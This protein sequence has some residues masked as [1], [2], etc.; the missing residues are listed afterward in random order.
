MRL[1]AVLAILLSLTVTAHAQGGRQFGVWT[2]ACDPSGYCSATAIDLDYIFSIGRHAEQSY[3]ELRYQATGDAVPDPAQGLGTRVDGEAFIFAPDTVGA[4]GDD[5][6]FYL[7][8]DTAQALMDR[9]MPGA[10]L[11]VSFFEADGR[12]T[13]TTFSLSGLTAALLWIDEQQGR[14]GSERV[15]SAPP[16]GLVPVY[17]GT[18]VAPDLPLALLDRHR[19]DPDCPPFEELANGRDF[20]VGELGDGQMVYLIPCVAAAYNYAHK[21]YVGS[22]D[23][24]YFDPQYFADF[25]SEIGWMGTPYIWNGGYDAATRTLT[26]F[27]KARGP[28]DCGSQGI[29]QWNGYAF[30]LTEMRSRD[31]DAELDPNGE[32]PEFPVIYESE[33]QTVE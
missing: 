6:S 27:M 24:P 18:A 11:E 12:P 15:A 7:L 1:L 21:V 5:R 31:C 16:Y 30:V 8:G 13:L 26:S 25:S 14:I 23:G 33:V 32:L 29:W 20:Q 17:P 2:A 28:A 4:Y 9:M 3:W 19:I 10:S 22:E